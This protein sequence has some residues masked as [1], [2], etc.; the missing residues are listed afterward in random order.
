MP[1][2]LISKDNG[3]VFAYAPT[4]AKRADMVQFMGSLD[5]A[6][7]RSRE[8]LAAINGVDPV[9]AALLSDDVDEPQVSRL[10]VI[11]AAIRQ[12]DDSKEANNF[13]QQGI[14]RIESIEI[15][16]GM[17]VTTAERDEAWAAV[18]AG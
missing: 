6:K 15:L 1:K 13:T 3:E 5:E 10:E 4:L 12:L 8:M 16:T 2:F 9:A 7:A 17:D 14:P 18:K 11:A